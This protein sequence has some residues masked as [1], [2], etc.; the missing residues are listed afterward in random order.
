MQLRRSIDYNIV[1][2]AQHTGTFEVLFYSVPNSKWL[3]EK[4]GCGLFAKPLSFSETFLKIKS[5]I[6]AQTMH[7]FFKSD[8]QRANW[9]I[10]LLEISRTQRDTV[11]SPSVNELGGAALAVKPH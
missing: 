11:T 3:K 5:I 10:S 7:S 8:I 4:I 1:M 6:D 9:N 2:N